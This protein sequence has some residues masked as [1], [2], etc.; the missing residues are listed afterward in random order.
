MK[1]NI[2]VDSTFDNTIDNAIEL[3]MPGFLKMV[4]MAMANKRRM[5]AEGGLARNRDIHP[6]EEALKGKT[7][8]S[9]NFA[10]R[11]LG[12]TP[13]EARR[14]AEVIRWATT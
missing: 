3:K 4:V 7:Q 1:K 13:A 2:N 10:Y 14:I 5:T 6:D 8:R 9:D 11:K 12:F